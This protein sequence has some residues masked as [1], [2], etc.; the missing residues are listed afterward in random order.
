M[1]VTLMQLLWTFKIDQDVMIFKNGSAFL[2]GITSV[3][4]IIENNYYGLESNIIDFINP[5]ICGG[6]F[7]FKEIKFIEI[8]LK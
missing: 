5:E 3:R 8:Y 6:V 1:D 2:E 4:T 7:G